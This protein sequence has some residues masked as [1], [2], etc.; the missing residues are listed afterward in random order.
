MGKILFTHH[1][2]IGAANLYR[3]KY[4]TRLFINE[5][6]SENSISNKYT[7]DKLLTNGFMVDNIEGF[8]INGHTRGFTFYIYKEHLFVCDYVFL[9]E[10]GMRFNPYGPFNST[11]EGALRLKK[12]IDGKTI[13]KVCGYDYVINYEEWKDGFNELLR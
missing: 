2:F 1:H 6:D 11:R 7:F 10:M 3:N 5:K 9:E 12:I 8:H 4:D 13:D